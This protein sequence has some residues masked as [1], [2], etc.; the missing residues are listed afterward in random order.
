VGERVEDVGDGDHPADKRYA[1]TSEPA[2]VSAA[3]PPLVM[4]RGDDG[5]HL[6][7]GRAALREQARA[8][9]RMSLYHLPLLSAQAPAL[10]QDAVWDRDLADVV[11]PR[12]LAYARDLLRSKPETGSDLRSDDPDALGVLEGRCGSGCGA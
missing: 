10:E 9:P 4:C 8:K 7:H 11:E 2:G 5:G 12:R 3:V 6:K 1:L